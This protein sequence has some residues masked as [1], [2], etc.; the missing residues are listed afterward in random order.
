MKVTYTI[1]AALL[2]IGAGVIVVKRDSKKDMTTDTNSDVVTEG[3]ATT[4]TTIGI[5]TLPVSNQVPIPTNGPGN[6]TTGDDARVADVVAVDWEGKYKIVEFGDI[7]PDSSPMRYDAYAYTDITITKIDDAYAVLIVLTKD[8][9]KTT[10]QGRGVVNSVSALE[11]YSSDQNL[12]F[13]LEAYES[14]RVNADTKL[15]W[16]NLK[17]QLSNTA[18]VYYMERQDL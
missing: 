16:V 4:T 14:D 6:V 15:T 10:L 17:P 12:L 11:V 8:T 7:V 2:I 18:G 1:I 5:S 3:G 9:S 13:T